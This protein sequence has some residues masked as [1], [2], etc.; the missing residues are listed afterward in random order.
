MD[1][2]DNL[3]EWVYKYDTENGNYLRHT[4]FVLF[5]PEKEVVEDEK[6]VKDERLSPQKNAMFTF[7]K[8]HLNLKLILP[9]L[10]YHRIKLI[11][12]TSFSIFSP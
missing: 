1:E 12:G 5:L 3:Y 9:F 4:K 6:K 10:S 8:F 7:L 11:Y 2:T